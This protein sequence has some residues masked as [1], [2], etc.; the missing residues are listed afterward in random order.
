LDASS[1]A[2]PQILAAAGCRSS[3]HRPDTLNPAVAKY[4]SRFT[5]LNRLVRRNLRSDTHHLFPI[6]LRGL[7]GG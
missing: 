3:L 6:P 2:G 5:W 7:Y 1:R 4:T